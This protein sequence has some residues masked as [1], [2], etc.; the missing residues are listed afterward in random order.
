MYINVARNNTVLALDDFHMLYVTERDA[1][2]KKHIHIQR[3]IWN[4][5]PTFK[6]NFPV[7]IL[8]HT[9]PFYSIKLFHVLQ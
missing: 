6:M 5:R 8:E 2:I 1:D 4:V 9:N 3:T 7:I